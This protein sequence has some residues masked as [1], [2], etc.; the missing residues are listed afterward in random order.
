MAAEASVVP[1]H[2]YK[3]FLLIYPNLLYKHKHLT[4]AVQDQLHSKSKKYLCS[5]FGIKLSNLITVTLNWL[6]KR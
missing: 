2:H 4:V 5:E 6:K 1:M 3:K